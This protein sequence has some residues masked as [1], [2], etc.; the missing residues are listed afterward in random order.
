MSNLVLQTLSWLK[1]LGMAHAMVFNEACSSAPP[2]LA[3]VLV[4]MG[5]RIICFKG[6]CT[7]TG[8]GALMPHTSNSEATYSVCMG[9]FER[10]PYVFQGCGLQV[11]IL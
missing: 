2:T 8:V 3:A 4:V 6:L 1:E 7:E 9:H 10:S 11:I 5:A